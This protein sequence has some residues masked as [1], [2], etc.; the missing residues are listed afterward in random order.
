M[1]IHYR[2]NLKSQA[3][4]L[5]NGSTQAEIRIRKYLKG[6][7]LNDRLVRQKPVGNCMV[8]FYCREKQLT[9]KLD[10]YSHQWEETIE[11]DSQKEKYLNS[12]GMGV[13]RFQ[14]AEVAGAI[15]NVITGITGTLR[16]AEENTASHP[17]PGV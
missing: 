14:D 2:N 4:H 16:N 17:V 7:Q 11:R 15:D 8:D 6:K 3:L 10:G 12:L 1:I 5:H 9:V 13:L